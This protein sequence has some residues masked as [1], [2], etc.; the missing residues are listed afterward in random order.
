[1]GKQDLSHDRRFH[2]FK[3]S[4][5]ASKASNSG[6]DENTKPMCTSASPAFDVAASVQRGT[7]LPFNSQ[8]LRSFFG[9]P[10]QSVGFGTYSREQ[11]NEQKSTF[12]HIQSEQLA[13]ARTPL[14]S[15]SQENREQVNLDRL[16][17]EKVSSKEYRRM[18]EE[19]DKSPNF[20]ELQAL[21]QGR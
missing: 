7:S 12:L 13:P 4:S 11:A 20:A 2:P 19:E 16:W 17:W 8:A 14:A 5:K 15:L 1:M 21:V 10:Q 6:T 18:L 3:P 9:L